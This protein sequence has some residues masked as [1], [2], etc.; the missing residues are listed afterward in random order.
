MMCNPFRVGC[1]SLPITQGAL[2]SLATLGCVVKPLRGH[3]RPTGRGRIH[4]RGA[5][6]LLELV[7]ALAVMA[8]ILGLAF[9]VLMRFSA[10]HTLKENVEAVRARLARTRL[11]AMNSGLTWQFRYEPNGRRCLVLPQQ[12]P[13]SSPDSGDAAVDGN[14]EAIAELLELAEGLRFLPSPPGPAALTSQSTTTE[15]LAE[16]WLTAFGA[17]ASLAEVG[18]AGAILF[19]PDGTAQ[20]ASLVV[21]D[22]D[23]RYQVLSVRGLTAAATVEPIERE[24]RR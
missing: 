5:F 12:R 15:R 22:D 23:G 1:R 19:M 6:T 10:E 9:P 4:L 8:A 18:W 21:V 3:S 14:T 20:D 11:S 2:A 13:L 7:L 24:R 16:D 17:P